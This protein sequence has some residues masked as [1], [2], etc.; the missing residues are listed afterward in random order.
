VRVG[1]S[2][3]VEKGGDVI[4]KIV[5]AIAS[6]RQGD[7]PEFQMPVSCPVCGAH[8]FRPEGEAIARCENAQCPAKIKGALLHYAS[9]RAMNIEGLGEALVDQLVGGAL[10]RNF[11][12]LYRL[13]NS[14]LVDLE[15]MGEKSAQNLLDEIEASKKNEFSRLLFGLGIRF[16]GERTASILA[17]HFLSVMDLMQATREDLETIHEIGPR[18]AESVHFFFQQKENQMLIEKLIVVGVN[19]YS[20]V[21]AVPRDSPMR[22]KQFVLTGAL[23]SMSRDEARSRIETLGGRVTSAVS[24]NTHFVVA[25]SD[26]G[27]K[28]EKARKLGI[29]VLTEAE[30]LDLLK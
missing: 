26:P 20:S 5:Q 17:E 1:D 18:I 4:P 6:R 10:V 19:M 24:K 14:Q 28:L 9:R 15:R 25:G 7:L 3:L 29:A 22:G 23:E 12:D 13:T 30:F 27:S 11:A 8:V 16:V 2:V 21:A